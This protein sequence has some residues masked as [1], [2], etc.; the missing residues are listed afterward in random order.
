M[1]NVRMARPAV[2][3]G[4]DY[5]AARPCA[6]SVHRGV[7]R[8]VGEHRDLPP[9]PL[10]Y[11]SP[12]LRGVGREQVRNAGV[13]HEPTV[14]PDLIFE[15]PPRSPKLNGRVERANRTY[16][17]EVYDC[18]SAELTVA[19][20]G[21]ELHRGERICNHIRPHQALRYLTPA[22]FLASSTKREV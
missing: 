13:D 12:Q 19:A 1:S 9:L 11:G 15:L 17:E 6:P 16:G 8:E 18:S 3:I 2:F 4:T 7:F 20:L 5:A 22:E 21:Q 10:D 14:P